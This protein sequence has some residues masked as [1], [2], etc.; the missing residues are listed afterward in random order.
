VRRIEEKASETTALREKAS[1]AAAT[2][3]RT[4]ERLPYPEVPSRSYFGLRG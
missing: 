4:G 1:V 3:F 2:R